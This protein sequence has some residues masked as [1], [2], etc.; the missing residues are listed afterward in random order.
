MA[1]ALAGRGVELV[2]EAVLEV[3]FRGQCVGV[4]R[5]DLFVAGRVVVEIK[6]ASALTREHESQLLN[7]LHASHTSVGLLL[8]FGPKPT[9]KRLVQTPAARRH[10]G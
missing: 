3:V 7:Y 6:A 5:A 2:Q 4:F 8:N 10:R 9:F 1:L